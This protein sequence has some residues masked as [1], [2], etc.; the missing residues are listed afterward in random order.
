[1]ACIQ[2]RGKGPEH[3]VNA[4][5]NDDLIA[6]NINEVSADLDDVGSVTEWQVLEDLHLFVWSEL[7]VF[8]KRLVAMEFPQLGHSGVGRFDSPRNFR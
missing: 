3:V 7:A 2:D 4:D 8:I 6:V 5:P 1:M